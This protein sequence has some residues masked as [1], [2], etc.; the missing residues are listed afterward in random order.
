V[1]VSNDER[2]ASGCQDASC[3]AENM[4]IAAASY[5]VGSVWLNPLRT[6][7]HAEPVSSFLDDCG[8][9]ENHIVWAMIALGYPAS[10]V[11]SPQR[12][13]DVVHIIR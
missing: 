3:A 13:S 4:M 1:L 5:G 6:L 7:R 9:P 10:D 8:I 12:R 11:S 2:N